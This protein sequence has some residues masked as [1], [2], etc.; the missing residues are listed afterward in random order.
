MKKILIVED[1]VSTLEMLR[2][3]LSKN[4]YEVWIEKTGLNIVNVVK[5]FKP[6]LVLLDAVLPDEDGY[7]LQK[8]L[9]KDK[10]TEHIPII[11][12]TAHPQFDQVFAGKENVAEFLTKPFN[13]DELRNKVASTLMKRL[14]GKNG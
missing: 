2:M 4:G 12:M 13:V 5:K 3:L 10:E 9:Y 8:K 1:D 11:M 6:D 7:S 14:E